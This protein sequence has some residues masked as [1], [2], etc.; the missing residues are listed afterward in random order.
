MILLNHKL[1]ERKGVV[2]KKQHS[3]VPLILVFCMLAASFSSVFAAPPP[4]PSS[5]YGTV[6]VDG[7][8]MPVDTPVTAWI[9][10]V[11]YASALSS[12]YQG[13]SVYTLNIPG[14]DPETVGFTEGGLE[15]DVIQFYIGDDLAEQTAAWH[16]GTNVQ[17]ALTATTEITVSASDDSYKTRIN[18]TLIVEA[19]G[20]LGNDSGAN[21]TAVKVSDS[22]HGALTLNADGSFTYEPDTDYVG[23][24]SFT[25]KANDG[26]TDSNT[27]TVVITVQPLNS[28]PVCAGSALATNKNTL[29]KLD[30]DCA[31]ADGDDLA[32][33]IVSPPAFGAAYVWDDEVIY[34]PNPG[35][36]GADSFSYKAGD[37]EEESGAAAVDV[38]VAAATLATKPPRVPALKSP[39]NK[40]LLTNNFTPYLDWKDSNQPKG[41]EF[42]YYQLQVAKDSGFSDMV[43]EKFITGLTNSGYQ[44]DPAEALVH[45]QRYYWRVRAFNTF[46]QYKGWSKVRYFREAMLAPELVLQADG[47]LVDNLRPEFDWDDVEGASGYQ[48]QISVKPNMGKPQKYKSLESFFVPGKDLQKNKV[49]YWRVRAT[50]ENGPSPWS[51]TRTIVTPNTPKVPVLLSPKNKAVVA[52]L[53]PL[54]RWKASV[55]PLGTEFKHYQ[56]QVSDDVSFGSVNI[57]VNIP[58][59]G[60]TQYTPEINLD[61]GTRYY[62]RVRAYN[63]D[64]HYSSWS[65]V[66]W[67]TTSS[68]APS[69]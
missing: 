44:I 25:Y 22:A 69:L 39:A 67:F 3:A 51:Q 50:G 65:K 43:V 1:S 5:F 62:W 53:T 34:I 31:D 13:A 20:V 14:D 68:L 47:A 32:Y 6:K 27:A 29:A 60:S 21:L 59:L 30:P 49:L 54:L 18:Q 24:D 4:L 38:T 57:D 8:N 23:E 7:E 33:E 40:K 37:G 66:F 17:L 42:A 55:V 41:T 45:N 16:S 56:L 35:F 46:G 48:I 12:M 52:T 26:T 11:Q 2:M 19:P 28:A 64:D 61:P 10:G 36:Y 58:G 15:G 9:N 63:T